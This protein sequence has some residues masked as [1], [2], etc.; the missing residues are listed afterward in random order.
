M[1]QVKNLVKF[2]GKHCVL[3]NVSFQADKGELV[4]I[5]GINGAGKTTL[6]DTILNHKGYS[7][8]EIIFKN[9]LLKD[10]PTLIRRMGSLLEP[11]FFSYLT[12]QENL[13]LL[14]EALGYQRKEQYKKIDFWLKRY[15]LLDKKYEK[16]KNLSFGQRQ[17]VGLIQALN[18]E[19]ELLL[20][21][22]PFIG[23]DPHGKDLLKADLKMLTEKGTC[24]LCSSHDLYDVGEISDRILYLKD[25]H[26]VYDGV[27]KQHRTYK[28]DV[29]GPLDSLS[30]E[31]EE[32]L[33]LV[34]IDF[35]NGCVMVHDNKLL[36]QIFALLT[37][38]Q[39]TIEDITVQ[40]NSLYDFFRE[41]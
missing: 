6:F 2:Y 1:L 30:L 39:L 14:Q 27:F 31:T 35:N 15:K 10:H 7:S 32:H 29:R 37:E 26:F 17:R 22:E 12:V 8:G 5:I 4:G 13:L 21:D 38:H 3:K 16:V 24:I 36:R 28:I 18:H 25:G 23:L 11:Q 19:A 41:E 20:L 40:E 33:G 9:Q 34:T